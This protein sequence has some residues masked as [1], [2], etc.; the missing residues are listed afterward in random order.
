[1]T[2]PALTCAARLAAHVSAGAVIKADA[3]GLGAAH[4]GPALY[5]AGWREFFVASLVEAREARSYLPK[6]ARIIVL[7]GLLSG[8]E[9]E[10]IERGLNHV[11]FSRPA[12]ERG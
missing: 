10:F 4:V 9:G 7:G 12:I 6:D 11:L 8:E 3:Y 2:A 5:R 1:M